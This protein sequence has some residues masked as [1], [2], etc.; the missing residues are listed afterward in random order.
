MSNLR[1]K[2]IA[3]VLER[4]AVWPHAG[5]VAKAIEAAISSEPTAVPAT[6][7]DR[8]I[9]QRAEDSYAIA[10]LQS[11]LATQQAD[12]AALSALYEVA[13]SER[14]ALTR[15]LAATRTLFDAALVK[16]DD[17]QARLEAA[18]KD[19]ARINWLAEN[20]YNVELDSFDKKIHGDKWGWRFLAP[21]NVQGDIRRVLDAAISAALSKKEGKP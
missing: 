6:G 21:P 18:E 12:F 13:C 2:K 9:Y 19:A 1:E 8:A 10:D 5:Q 17:L 20:F 4:F 14:D 15:T 7:E 3:E 11:Q 16:C